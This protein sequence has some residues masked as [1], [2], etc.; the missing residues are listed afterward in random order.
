[1]F[2]AP[3]R[4][5]EVKVYFDAQNHV[6]AFEGFDGNR[7]LRVQQGINMIV[8]GLETTNKAD[9]DPDAEFPI[10]PVVW[11]TTDREGYQSTI[12][13]PECF[14]VQWHNH[15]QCTLVDTNSSL[16]E[17]PHKFNVLVSY[18]EQTYGTDPVIINQP[19]LSGG[20]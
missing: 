2:E 7:T 20:G 17:K 6:F 18:K 10:Y 1:M 19:P 16:I 11:F 14:D 12:H 13:Q 9:G 15:Q 4:I 3:V 5:Y 8:L